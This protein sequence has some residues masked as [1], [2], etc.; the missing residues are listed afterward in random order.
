MAWDC[1]IL[2]D[3]ESTNLAHSKRMNA[4]IGVSR[5]IHWLYLRENCQPHQSGC[6]N[7]KGSYLSLNTM[8]AHLLKGPVTECHRWSSRGWT[9]SSSPTIRS[10]SFKFR[11]TSRTPRPCRAKA[12]AAAQ[13]AIPA[14][15]T[16]TSYFFPC[17]E[18]SITILVVEISW[19]PQSHKG[20]WSSGSIWAFKGNNLSN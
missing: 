1:Y 6:L 5:L 14:P 9:F 18:S 7:A 16:R 15:I 11:S 2:E 13:L 12:F 20:E 17:A 8:S 3:L 19:C 4:E 10:G